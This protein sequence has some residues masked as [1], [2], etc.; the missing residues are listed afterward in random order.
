MPNLSI[1][2]LVAVLSLNIIIKLHKSLIVTSIPSCI[3]VSAPQL[4]TFIYLVIA[5]FSKSLMSLDSNLLRASIKI[6]NFTML[7]AINLTSSL[8][9]ISF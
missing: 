4:G 2:T 5:I 3:Y 1:N 8:Y 7:A 6:G 9:F